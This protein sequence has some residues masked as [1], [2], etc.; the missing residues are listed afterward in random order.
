MGEPNEHREGFVLRYEPIF[1]GRERSLLAGQAREGSQGP[2]LAGCWR[3][4][5]KQ[6]AASDPVLIDG[7]KS[8]DHLATINWREA[9]VSRPEDGLIGISYLMDPVDGDIVITN[10][11]HWAFEHTG[12]SEGSELKG[13]LGY[14]VDGATAH[15]P[16]G[17]VVLASSP[18]QN[19]LDPSRIGVANMATHATLSGGQVFATGSIQWCWGLDDF[20]AP[21]LRT[22]R[23]SDA[24]ARITHNVL[25]RFGA[26]HFSS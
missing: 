20:N 26:R 4:I 3:S 18:A 24:A 6:A 17:L 12:L 9:P 1:L 2:C 13:L 10:P 11:S 7:D 22:S 15:A 19:L 5:R 16:N 8:N 23:L 25:A 21:E 14:E